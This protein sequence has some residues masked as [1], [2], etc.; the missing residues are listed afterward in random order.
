MSILSV[1]LF[2]QVFPIFRSIFRL[3]TIDFKPFLFFMHI[4]L[5]LDFSV[6]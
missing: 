1:S 6:F 2:S 4:L 3:T 5:C